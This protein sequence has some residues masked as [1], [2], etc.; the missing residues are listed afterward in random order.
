MKLD[1]LAPKV[2]EKIGVL[3]AG[4]TATAED[5][6]KAREKLSAAHAAV[7]ARRLDRWT[8]NNLPETVIE[9]YINLAAVL[10][11][12]DFGATAGGD[13]WGW[14]MGEISTAAS[15]MKAQGPIPA[16]YF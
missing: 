9:P 12:P 11:A 13:W 8:R 14:A 2:L 6:I 5:L 15:T 1:D 16:E 4:E 7:R 10:V 3:G